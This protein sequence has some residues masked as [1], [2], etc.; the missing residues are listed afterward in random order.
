[1][2]DKDFPTKQD[3]E[4]VCVAELARVTLVIKITGDYHMYI[5]CNKTSFYRINEIQ[6]SFYRLILFFL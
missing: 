4:N 1:M 6:Q 3:R 2:P 5:I